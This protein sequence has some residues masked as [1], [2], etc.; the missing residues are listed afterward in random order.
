MTDAD[1]MEDSLSKSISDITVH[2]RV[3][4]NIDEHHVDL[5]ERARSGFSVPAGIMM[6]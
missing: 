6:T 5:V 1:R 2:I 4:S 3:L